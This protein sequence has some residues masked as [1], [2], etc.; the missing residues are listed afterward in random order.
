VDNDYL[1]P[2]DIYNE[3]R[4]ATVFDR[5]DGVFFCGH[6]HIAGIHTVA[7]YMTPESIDSQYTIRSTDAVI[8]VGSAGQPRDGDKR[9]SF[10][11]VD[12]NVVR[13]IR[14]DYDIDTT[15]RKLHD[16]GSGPTYWDI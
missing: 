6:F 9:A 5:F 12:G 14:L 16:G 1:F 2:E 15:V 10:V 11:I 13:F 7:E 3:R 8:N 4:M